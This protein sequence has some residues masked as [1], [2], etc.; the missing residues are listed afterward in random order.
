[1]QLVQ[2]TEY[3]T[4]KI[5]TNRNRLRPRIAMRL[6]LLRRTAS[7][8]TTAGIGTATRVWMSSSGAAVIYQV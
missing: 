1:L 5:T 3:V 2:K 4:K 6:S 7:Q 8:A